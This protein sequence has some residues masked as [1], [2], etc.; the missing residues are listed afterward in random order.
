MYA[1]ADFSGNWL[2]DYAEFDLT[3]VKSRSGWVITYTNCPI[4]LASKLQSQV[5]LSTIE[6]KYICLS[7]ALC[8]VI[9][10][11]QLA[12]ENHKNGFEVC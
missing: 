10:L 12:N 4:S 7:T 2:K 6:T 1:D 8:N 9:P 5:A 3:T 11:M